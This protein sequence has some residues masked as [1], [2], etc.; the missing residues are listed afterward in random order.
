MLQR[1]W[2]RRFPQWNASWRRA[3][4]RGLLSGSGRPRTRRAFSCPADRAGVHAARAGEIVYR[5]LVVRET[6]FAC[7]ALLFFGSA[8]YQCK[9]DDPATVREDSPADALWTLCGRFALDGN[10]KA[11][12][13]TLDELV[14]RYPSSRL[15]KRAEDER[16]QEHPC[17]SVAAEASARRAKAAAKGSVSASVP[18]AVSSASASAKQ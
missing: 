8:P 5:G 12:R 17:A 1:G 15:A 2:R 3:A 9:S 13:E 6:V 11:A 14:E 4:V 10:D 16:K 18:S 7:S